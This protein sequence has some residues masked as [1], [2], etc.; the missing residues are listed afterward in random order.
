MKKIS[1]KQN[2]YPTI[3]I[4]ED[5]PDQSEMLCDYLKDEGYHVDTAFSGDSAL[6]KLLAHRFNLMV[7]DFPLQGLPETEVLRILRDRVSHEQLPIIVIAAFATDME[8]NRYQIL[9]AN[10][11]ISKPYDKEELVGVVRALLTPNSA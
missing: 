5:D 2:G 4:A 9:G 10:A 6:L 8:V 11:C 7:L 3:L 1:P